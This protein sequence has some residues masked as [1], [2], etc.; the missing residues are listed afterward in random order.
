ME[1]LFL[2]YCILCINSDVLRINS[3]VDSTYFPPIL[4][5]EGVQIIR[6]SQNNSNLNSLTDARLLQ[7]DS[8]SGN[9]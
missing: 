8:A 3:Y 4:P 7:G 5:L 2:V 1:D 6:H 9:G